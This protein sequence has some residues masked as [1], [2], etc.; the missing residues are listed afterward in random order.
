MEHLDECS[1]CAGKGHLAYAIYSKGDITTVCP[2][3]NG[4][5]KQQAEKASGRAGTG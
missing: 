2:I 5:G 1:N 4:T 3:C